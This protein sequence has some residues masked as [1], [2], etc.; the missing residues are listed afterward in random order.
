MI[1]RAKHPPC[2]ICGERHECPDPHYYHV[3]QAIA[4]MNNLGLRPFAEQDG[5][6]SINLTLTADAERLARYALLWR[7]D[8]EW[9]YSLNRAAAR[10]RWG[11][12]R[13]LRRLREAG[14]KSMAVKAR[15]RWLEEKRNGDEWHAGRVV[16]C[17]WMNYEKNT[18]LRL[19]ESPRQQKQRPAKNTSPA[20]SEGNRATE[21]TG[22]D[23][24]TVCNTL[25][26]G[27]VLAVT[28]GRPDDPRG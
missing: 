4:R 9:Y 17:R 3:E 2:P 21:R 16:L 25:S 11:V 5:S 14:D 8:L 27:N 24:R 18:G 15:K 22:G 20:T 7:R 19:P 1:Q 10:P 26:P 23:P 28:T 6:V 12:A 13:I